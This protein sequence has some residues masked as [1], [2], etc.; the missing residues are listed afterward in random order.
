[1]LKHVFFLIYLSFFKKSLLKLQE[2]QYNRLNKDFHF[3]ILKQE[4]IPKMEK[5]S[6][7]LNVCG[8]TCSLRTDESEEYMRTLESQ[9][10]DLMGAMLKSSNMM[11]IELA[12]VSSALMFCDESIKLKN[13]LEHVKEAQ[14]QVQEVV[15][16]VV[17]EVIKEVPVSEYDNSKEIE[18]EIKNIALL[19][20]VEKL[21]EEIERLNAQGNVDNG[22]VGTI[23]KA[24]RNS[25]GKY[26]NPM[27]PFEEYEQ[28]GFK[29]FFAGEEK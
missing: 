11:T 15:K 19:E 5:R 8:I 4:E 10:S 18:L 26:K 3:K 21:N 9:V 2:M 7:K 14:P 24:K 13:E 1:M 6:V 17:K 25:K 29:S 23:L 12:A 20:K 16:E 27:R 22:A 28:Q